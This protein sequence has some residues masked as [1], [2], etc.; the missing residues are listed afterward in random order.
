MTYDIVNK[1][2]GPPETARIA[3]RNLATR[4]NLLAPTVR[5]FKG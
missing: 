4:A 2:T 3:N 1:P 5:L